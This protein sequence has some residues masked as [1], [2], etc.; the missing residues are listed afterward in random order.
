MAHEHELEEFGK[1]AVEKFG[2]KVNFNV[3]TLSDNAKQQLL[4][5]G[6]TQKMIDDLQSYKMVWVVTDQDENRLTKCPGCGWHL[7][8]ILGAFTWDIAWG[9]GHCCSCNEVSFRVYHNFKD[10]EVSKTM[11]AFAVTGFI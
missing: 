1:L 11:P 7:D 6:W 3:L 2:D 10:G 4:T 9:C 5:E 8:G